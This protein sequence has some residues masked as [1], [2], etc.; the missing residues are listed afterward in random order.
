[1]SGK[2][3][4]LIDR[5]TAASPPAQRRRRRIDRDRAEDGV[6][7]LVEADQRSRALERP[8]DRTRVL[9][10]TQ[11]GG[12]RQHRP[13]PCTQQVKDRDAEHLGQLGQLQ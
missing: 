10:V 3:P 5:R 4:T 1:V 9:E 13:L 11:A 8:V 6:E 7:Q 2:P 12:D